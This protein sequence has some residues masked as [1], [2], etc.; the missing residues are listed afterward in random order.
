MLEKLILLYMLA[1]PLMG[2]PG[3]A[4][5]S[6][7]AMGAAYGVRRSLVYLAGIIAGTV[8]VLLMIAT[9]VTALILSQPALVTA[10]SVLA[11]G[12]ILYLAYRIATAPVIQRELETSKSPSFLPGFTLAAANP[13]AYAALGSIYSGSVLVDG[14]PLADAAAKIAALGVMIVLANSLWLLF[15]SAFSRFLTEP[16]AARITNGLFAA[17]LIGSVLLALTRFSP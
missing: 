12:Y 7:A 11:V 4:V 3:P 9:G 1:I 8:A 10:I 17:M 5:L 15:G 6:M 13:K 14:A 2:S 16:K